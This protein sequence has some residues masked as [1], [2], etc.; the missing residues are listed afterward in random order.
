MKINKIT[1][2][3]L[4]IISV[5]ISF[6]SYFFYKNLWNENNWNMISDEIPFVWWIE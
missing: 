5:I 6:Y 3:I 4:I 2:I 1:L